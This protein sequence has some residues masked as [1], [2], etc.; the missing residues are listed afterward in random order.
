MRSE[1]VTM[2]FPATFSPIFAALLQTGLMEAGV[3][4]E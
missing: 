3:T 1:P 2:F 4:S